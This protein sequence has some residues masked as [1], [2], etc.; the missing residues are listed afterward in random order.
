MFTIAFVLFLQAFDSESDG[1]ENVILAVYSVVQCVANRSDLLSKLSRSLGKL[2]TSVISAQR[3]VATAFYAEL[4][5]KVNSDVIW[6]E[7]IVNTLQE[8]KADSSPLV[9]KLATIGLTKVASLDAKQVRQKMTK[10]LD[11]SVAIEKPWTL[12]NLNFF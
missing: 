8:A 5:G 9:R 12:S 10:F 2:M 1:E 3:A 4:I 11:R 7:A 6:L